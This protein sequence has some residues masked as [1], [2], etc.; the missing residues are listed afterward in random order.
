M[1]LEIPARVTRPKSGKTLEETCRPR[2]HTRHS[3][4]ELSP[5]RGLAARRPPRLPPHRG[6]APGPQPLRSP[7]QSR[8][9]H[10]GPEPSGGTWLLAPS[11]GTYY[12][13]R[14]MR[15]P[16]APAASRAET[17]AQDSRIRLRLGGQ[18]RAPRSPLRCH[19]SQTPRARWAPCMRNGLICAGYLPSHPS[20]KCLLEGEETESG[21]SFQ[22]GR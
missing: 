19:E 8:S 1:A 2:R 15:A 11:P 18:A 10:A 5:S 21:A 16:A 14:L 22:P 6:P 3:H 7:W 13:R 12:V 9:P 4:A 20:I 17:Q